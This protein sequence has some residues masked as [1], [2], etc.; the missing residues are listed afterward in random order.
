MFHYGNSHTAFF[1]A[2]LKSHMY[3]DLGTTNQIIHFGKN[4]ANS[5]VSAGTHSKLN[6][7]SLRSLSR[8]CVD[9]ARNEQWN[10][11]FS[12]LKI[13]IPLQ[14]YGWMSAEEEKYGI[15]VERR[16]RILRTLVRNLF[17]YHQQEILLTVLN[18]YTDWTRPFPPHPLSILDCEYASF[19]LAQIAV[20]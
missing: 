10:P 3:I 13:L 11:C 7:N 14:A 2:L 20:P 6:N 12:L 5:E 16:D 17:T 15:E 18:E 8:L 19:K 4:C 9:L 1:P